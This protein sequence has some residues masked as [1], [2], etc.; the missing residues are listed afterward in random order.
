MQALAQ[1]PPFA[2]PNLLQS[3]TASFLFILSLPPWTSRSTGSAILVPSSRAPKAPPHTIDPN[4]DHAELLDFNAIEQGE[5][6]DPALLQA[7][8]S[9]VQNVAQ[10]STKSEW[11]VPKGSKNGKPG[12]HRQVSELEGSMYI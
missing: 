1:L 9:I 7:I 10:D 2:P 8:H 4:S 3:T 12:R 6:W 5:E 11:Q